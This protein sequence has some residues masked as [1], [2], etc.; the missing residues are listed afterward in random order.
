VSHSWTI[1]HEGNFNVDANGAIPEILNRM[2]VRSHPG[3]QDLLPALPRAWPK[4][5]IR[6][7]RARQQITINRLAWDR[8]AKRLTLELT[9]D[10]D[11]AIALALP[12]VEGIRT[13]EVAAGHGK[14][15]VNAGPR[16]ARTL[17]VKAGSRVTL[18]IGW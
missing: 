8:G 10:R 16:N 17:T 9:S 13:I 15:G 11:Q 6:G 12:A 7:I 1:N 2:L 14:P 3:S 18:E 4:G 5:E